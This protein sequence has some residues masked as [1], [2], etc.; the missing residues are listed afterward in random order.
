MAEVE[1][2]DFERAQEFIK[3]QVQTEFER[4]QAQRAPAPDP[5]Q[6][7]STEDIARQQLREAID[8]IYRGDIDQARF[9]SQDAKDYVDFYSDPESREY[10]E[11][12]ERI[13]AEANKAGRPMPRRDIQRWLIGKEVIEQ[14]DKYSER[15][16][17]RKQRELDRA[18]NAQDF[19]VGAAARQK[20]DQ[21]FANFSS[22]SLEEMEK[23][24]DGV[25]F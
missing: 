5:V 22:L 14:P 21:T 25:V 11:E 4:L 17:A 16:S 10:K 24:L 13:F 1:Q 23:A 12:V 8:P 6:G 15:V 2:T 19:G 18:G 3:S 20:A 9:V 7:R